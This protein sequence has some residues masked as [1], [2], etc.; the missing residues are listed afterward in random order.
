MQRILHTLTILAFFTFFGNVSVYGEEYAFDYQKIVETDQPID[1]NLVMA[2]GRATIVGGDDQRLIVE[3]V[4]RVRATSYDEAQEVADHIEIRVD[5]S[6][7][8]IEIKTNYLKLGNRNRGFWNKLLGVGHDSY[9]D[10]DFKITLPEIRSLAVTSLA[11][12][13]ELS[14]IEGEIDV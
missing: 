7:E 9:G 8:Q 2:N 12:E 14:S 1:L 13:I 3:A 6:G 5:V 10:V 11:A 4:K